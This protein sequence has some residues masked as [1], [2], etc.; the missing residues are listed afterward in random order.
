M[1]RKVLGWFRTVLVV[2]ELVL[3]VL[4]NMRDFDGSRVTLE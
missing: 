1:A 2:L 4:S 3:D